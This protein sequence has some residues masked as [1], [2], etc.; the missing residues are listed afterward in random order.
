MKRTEYIV[1]TEMGSTYSKHQ[2]VY[3]DEDG[4]LY[5][6]KDGEYKCIENLPCKEYM[7]RG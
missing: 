7:S 5:I 2:R 3:K 1:M 4:K 6:R